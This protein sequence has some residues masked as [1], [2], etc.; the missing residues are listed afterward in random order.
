[1]RFIGRRRGHI[2]GKR[3][4][5]IM[6]KKLHRKVAI[7]AAKAGWKKGKQTLP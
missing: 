2:G 6:T 4:L 1:M 5:K 3:R 7:K